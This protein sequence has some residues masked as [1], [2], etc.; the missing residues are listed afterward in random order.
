[1]RRIRA[2]ITFCRGVANVLRPATSLDAAHWRERARQARALAEQITDLEARAR[3]LRNAADYEKLA[4]K[5]EAET[6]K[7]ARSDR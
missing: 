7:I 1:M 2:A 3:M 5:A 4:D 6:I